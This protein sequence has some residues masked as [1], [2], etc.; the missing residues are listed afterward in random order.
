MP[1]R[2]RTDTEDNMGAEYARMREDERHRLEG[3]P[4][5]QQPEANHPVHL[6]EPRNRD[7]MGRH[8]QPE[9]PRRRAEDR[10]EEDEAGP[11]DRKK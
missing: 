1:R 10:Q 5:S 11:A 9:D 7:R 8:Y 2:R 6:E 4:D 3:L